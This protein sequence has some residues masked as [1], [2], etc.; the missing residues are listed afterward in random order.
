MGAAARHV[1]GA[2]EGPVGVA[3]RAEWDG[4]NSKPYRGTSLMRKRNPLGPYCRPVPRAL[5]GF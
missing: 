5:G 3:G 1:R 4:V 2:V